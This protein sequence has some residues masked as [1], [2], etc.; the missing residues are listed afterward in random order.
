MIKDKSQ[1]ENIKVSIDKHMKRYKY[2]SSESID[3]ELL[4]KMLKEE[5]EHNNTTNF[6]EE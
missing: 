3:E 6:S 5:Q 4:D 2:P 1:R